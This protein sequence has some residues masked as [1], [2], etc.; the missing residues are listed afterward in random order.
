MKFLLSSPAFANGATIPIKHTCDGAKISPELRWENPPPGTRSLVLIMHDPDTSHGDVTH[1]LLWDL[2]PSRRVLPEGWGNSERG[3][4]G[5]NEHGETSYLPPT[6]PRGEPAHRYI[7]E[8]YA[9]DVDELGLPVGSSRT[10]VEAAIRTHRLGETRLVGKFG[11]RKSW[12]SP[13]GPSDYKRVAIG[14][15]AAASASAPAAGEPARAQSAEPAHR[16]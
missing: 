2:P 3:A 13:N 11:R 15:P 12:H 5:A 4:T 8:L 14:R 16:Q 6:P 7:F 1:W 9:L 10:V